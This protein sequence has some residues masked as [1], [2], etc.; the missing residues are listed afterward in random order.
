[1]NTELWGEL[2]P[3]GAG[4]KEESAIP[5]VKNSREAASR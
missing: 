4:T 5:D 3:Q 1:L 2:E